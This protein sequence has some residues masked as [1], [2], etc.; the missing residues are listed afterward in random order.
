MLE[1]LETILLCVKE[2]AWAHFKML[3][4]KYVSKLYIFNIYV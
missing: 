3:S 4:T 1:I 2:L